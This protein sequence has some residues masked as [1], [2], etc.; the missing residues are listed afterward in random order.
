MASGE[1]QQ[2][3]KPTVLDRLLDDEPDVSQDPPQSRFERQRITRAN[4]MRDVESLLNARMRCADLPAELTEVHQTIVDYG[5]P[6]VTS[7]DLRT[8]R[9][10]REFYQRLEKAI[11]AFEPRLTNVRVEPIAN[12]DSTDSTV[13]FKIHAAIRHDKDAPPLVFDSRMDALGAVQLQ[14]QTG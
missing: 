14:D 1:S 7:F 5:I 8:R 9:G 11:A 12:S 6:D 10:Q 2:S 13:R 3:L 4:L